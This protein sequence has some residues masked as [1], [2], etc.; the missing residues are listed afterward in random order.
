MISQEVSQPSSRLHDKAAGLE[1]LFASVG[2]VQGQGVRRA[3]LLETASHGSPLW[4]SKR[5][6]GTAVKQTGGTE[7]AAERGPHTKKYT[8]REIEQ[9]KERNKRERERERECVCVCV[10]SKE[11][12]RER[13]RERGGGTKVKY[14]SRRGGE[15][16][17]SNHRSKYTLQVNQRH[18]YPIQSDGEYCISAVVNMLTCRG[19]SPSPHT[20]RVCVRQ[21]QQQHTHT[22]TQRKQKRDRDG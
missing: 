7:R 5:D 8:H 18:P 11:S 13:E 12:E 4:R 3:I 22:R 17:K 20:Q 2:A 15:G 16:H 10:S 14:N 9:Q 21:Q 1:I 19:M 6:S